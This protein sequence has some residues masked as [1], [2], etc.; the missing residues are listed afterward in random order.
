MVS[1]QGRR[2]PAG[3]D[4]DPATGKLKDANFLLLDQAAAEK[5]VEALRQGKYVVKSVEVKPFVE[6]PKP[7]FTTSTL[8]QEANRKMGF[9]ARRTM[10][11]AQ[12]LYENGY[13]T[14][15]RTD[16]TSLANEAVQAAR[17]L[18]QQ[19]Y[20]DSFLHPTP[21]VYASK[22]KNAQE[23][24]EAIR[25]AGHPFQ[26]PETLRGE[27]DHDQFRLFDMI[28]KR[29]IACQ[30]ADAN[31]ER[32]TVTIEADGAIFQA[33]GTTIKFEGFLRAYV[34]GSDDPEA[35]WHNK[36]SCCPPC[37]KATNSI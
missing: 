10:Q 2:I 16:S 32:V 23:A 5:L 22:V 29:T 6:R 33:S 8:Q 26:L 11:V 17:D 21:R 9:T 4:F 35:D 28:W 37:N 36:K 34:E 31:K 15:M 14:Y 25:P 13:I 7:P 24:H 30:M 20:G 27:L 18:V 19:Q 3:K 12:S 1:Y